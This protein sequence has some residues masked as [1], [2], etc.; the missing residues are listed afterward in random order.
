MAV[1]AVRQQK[2][3]AVERLHDVTAIA[4]TKGDNSLVVGQARLMQFWLVS[5]VIEEQVPKL[6]EKYKDE[7]PPPFPNTVNGSPEFPWLAPADG[8]VPIRLKAL[9]EPDDSS[10]AQSRS[11][12]QTRA[13]IEERDEHEALTE[14]LSDLIKLDRYERRALSRQLHAARKFMNIKLVKRLNDERRA[15]R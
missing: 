2:L 3:A 7:M 8:M 1:Q 11:S 13:E 15:R 9:L 4:L 5:R 14:A 6:M 10:G 12:N